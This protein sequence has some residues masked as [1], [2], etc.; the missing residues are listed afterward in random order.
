[1]GNN[2]NIEETSKHDRDV[3][4]YEKLGER[5][6][7]I[8]RAANALSDEAK[9]NKELY[10]QLFEK[11][12]LTYK[13]DPDLPG[14]VEIPYGIDNKP[15]DMYMFFRDKTITFKLIFPFR[16]ET[17]AIPIM[18][19]YLNELNEDKVFAHLHMDLIEGEI[20]MKYSYI[21]EDKSHFDEKTA[22][23]YMKSCV[24]PALEVYTRLSHIAVC[25]ALGKDKYIYDILMDE[26]LKSLR[27]SM[28]DKVTYG[29]EEIVERV[30]KADSDVPTL[31]KPT[32]KGYDS[33]KT[34]RQDSS[35]KESL[36]GIDDDLKKYLE[37]FGMIDPKDSKQG[38]TVVDDEYDDEDISMEDFMKLIMTQ[39]DDS[40][41]GKE[42]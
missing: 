41:D 1:M 26:S 2:N 37:G 27:G 24:D 42:D 7:E 8:M 21:L 19:M 28:V 38:E 13:C 15:F 16:V 25:Y 12:C 30:N 35:K 11:Y 40:S 33:R 36:S 14:K 18:S 17:A 31:F 4:H 22:W 6:D 39:D 9:A 23:T 32:L 34:E 5:I 10:I 3:A 29:T 20:F